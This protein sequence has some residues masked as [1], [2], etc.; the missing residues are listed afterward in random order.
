MAYDQNTRNRLQ[1]FVSEARNLLS[2][3]FTRQFQ[4]KYGLDPSSGEVSE[5][6]RLVNLD[7]RE[8]ETARILRYTLAHYLA[9]SP[10]GGKRE[11][12][13]RM[14]REQAFT[15]LNRL[16]AL[17]MAEARGIIIESLSKTYNSKGFQL[18]ARLAS[19]ALGDTG[20]AYRT[21]IFSLFDELALDMPVLFDRF[22]PQG[23]LFPG[24]EVLLELLTL[25]NESE[26]SLLWLEDETIGWIYQ[27]FNSQNERRKMRAESQSPRNSREMAVRNQFFT[28]RYVVEFLTDNALGRLWYEMT[29][30]NTQLKDSCRY[31]VHRPGEIFLAAGEEA[32]EM[33]DF[34]EDL[35][36]KELLQQAVYIPHRPLKDPREILM[37]DPACG[38]MHFGLYAFDL[39]EKIYEEAWDLEEELD[40]K[41]FERSEKLQPLRQCY[42]SK[43]N[44]LRDVPRLIVECN[45]HGV[46]IDPRAVQIA[47]LSLWLRAQRNWQLQGV[48]SLQRPQI[49]KS[50]VVCAEPMPGEKEMLEEFTRKLNPRVLGQ[51]VKMI[52]GKME[53][54]GEAGSLL[55]I[56]EEIEV[57]L[58]LAREEFQKEIHF[59]NGDGNSLFPNVTPRQIGIFDFGDLQVKTQFW[60]YAEEKLL[61][62]L[63]EYSEQADSLDSV[64]KRLFVQDA[65]RGFAFIDLLRKRYDVILMNPPFGEPSRNIKSYVE[66]EYY[67]SKGNILAHFIERNLE[68]MKPDGKMGAITSRSC[69]FLGSMP[70]FREEIL[71]SVGI[72]ELMADLGE[73][74][75]EAM[76]ETACYIISKPTTEKLDS[77]FF[78]CLVDVE[79][80]HSLY[81][82]IQSLNSNHLGKGIFIIN[83]KSF[84]NISGSPYCYWVSPQIIRKIAELPEFNNAGARVKVGLQT[85]DDNRFLRNYWEVEPKT[86]SDHS[87]VP[88]T[89]T[90]A[91]SPWYSPLT[92]VVNWA[93]TGYEIKNFTDSKGYQRSV[94]R[95]PELYG[96]AGFSYMSRTTRLVPYIVPKGCIPT[97]VRSTVYPNKGEEIASLALCGSNM[98][99]AIARFRGENFARPMFQAGM[100]QSLPYHG[101]SLG[102]TEKLSRIITLQIQKSK[103]F[104]STCEPFYDFIQCSFLKNTPAVSWSLDT[105]LT[106]EYEKMVAEEYGLSEEELEIL[107]YDLREA[108]Y[109][110][111]GVQEDID[112]TEDNEVE[113]KGYS[114]ADRWCSYHLGVVFGRWDIRYSTGHK[115][116]PEITD[117][118][119][120]LPVCPLGML[121]NEQGM[122]ATSQDVPDN[123][124]LWINWN[125]ILVDDEGHKDDII[126]ELR[127]AIEIIWKEKA[128]HIEQEAC[129]ILSV[130]S[131]RNYFRKPNYFF[132]EHLKCYTKN[133]RQA[134]IYWPLSTSSGSYTIW[135]YYPRLGDQ[136]LYR[137]VND[138]VEPKLKQARESTRQLRLKTGRSRQEEK[139]LEELVNLEQELQ[140]FRDE[141]L[142]VAAYWKPDFNDG[143]QITA[144]PLWKLFRLSKWRNSLKSTWSKLDK[145]DYD[146]A[147]LAFDIWP[148]RVRKKCMNDKSLAIAHNLENIYEEPVAQTKKKGGRGKKN[149]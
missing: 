148:D 137:C 89:K 5:L 133:R 96:L 1:R 121:L 134:P 27:Y 136:T 114:F 86:I 82:K 78:R 48:K 38:S 21:Y 126:A 23:R 74:V 97:A 111:S 53:L 113:D 75:L 99:S 45:I 8:L 117:P 10:S 146:W 91:A 32:P 71:G 123:Y 103:N 63:K 4:Q 92:L 98:G 118:F 36:Q 6:E 144:A 141:L 88:Y 15:V 87:W 50:N 90:E 66:F 35:N 46:D 105:L 2:D 55:K 94:V 59:R 128:G 22:S 120:P 41:I 42:A 7:D 18:Y 83:T 116:V 109:I 138:Y 149:T 34:T 43:E 51:L 44:F 47:G 110:R 129:E 64:Q 3:E 112:D 20:E 119:K 37:L 102:L 142:R 56:E 67:R 14:I 62:A 65:A 122:S 73:G 9:S 79:K 61:N 72:I 25:M 77:I 70:R 26:L 145:G 135:L 69:L 76:V 81:D 31:L 68:L 95:S 60:N 124:P 33:E 84:R 54:A 100:I 106:A 57:A 139:V 29:H 16:S 24:K 140:E 104:L 147:H 101:L 80:Q 39:Y 131:L 108:I 127:K 115:T 12:L 132:A 28:P 58:N 11:C 143:V 107:E 30:G 52:F 49:R 85:G 40:A 19:T 17:C 130:D 125:G 93:N 13:E